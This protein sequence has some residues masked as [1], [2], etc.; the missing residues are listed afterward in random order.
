MVSTG[1][2]EDGSHRA[3]KPAAK[4]GLQYRVIVTITKLRGIQV[5]QSSS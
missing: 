1:S 4:E 3:V 5:E 2:A